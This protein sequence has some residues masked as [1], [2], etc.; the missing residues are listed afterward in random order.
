MISMI[1]STTIMFI[2]II[3][4]SIIIDI[5]ICHS[6]LTPGGGDGDV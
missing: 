5:Y 6:P 2:M 3:I 4:V 1:T